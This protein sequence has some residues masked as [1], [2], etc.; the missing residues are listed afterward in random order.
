MTACPPNDERYE[1][2]AS[3][4][5]N[6]VKFRAGLLMIAAI[7]GENFFHRRR[8]RHLS[9][10]NSPFYSPSAS[11]A[12]RER[13]T[14]RSSAQSMISDQDGIR[15]FRNPF[16]HFARRGDFFVPQFEENLSKSLNSRDKIICEPP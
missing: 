5:V 13:S 1:R 6:L 2:I 9:H 4:G 10:S 16:N 3:R 15:S 12:F 7:C 8:R 11:A 14:N